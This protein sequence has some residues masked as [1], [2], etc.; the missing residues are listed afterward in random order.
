APSGAHLAELQRAAQQLLQRAFQ[1][2]AC[3]IR[4]PAEHECLALSR[5]QAVIGRV[6]ELVLR[7]SVLAIGAEE[8]SSHVDLHSCRTVAHGDL[9]DGL[10]GTGVDA[11]LASGSA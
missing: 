3:I 11:G 2:A 5:G 4:L 8:A 9:P 10:R 6:T 7:A 1:Q